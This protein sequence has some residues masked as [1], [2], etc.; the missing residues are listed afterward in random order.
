[1]AGDEYNEPN[2]TGNEEYVE[3]SATG[4]KFGG[5]GLSQGPYDW[6]DCAFASDG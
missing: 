2:A 4:I 5:D 6:E 3:I 1:M